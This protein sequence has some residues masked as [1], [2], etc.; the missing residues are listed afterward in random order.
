[1]AIEALLGDDNFSHLPRH[2][3]ESILYV[4]LYI[5]TFTNGP[6]LPR[7]DFETPDTLNMKTWFTTDTVKIIGCRKVGHMCQPERNLISGFTEYWKDFTPF[8]L[9]LLHLCFPPTYNPA[10]P[11]KLTHEKMLSILREAKSTV[12]ELPANV[13][14][15]EE[16]GVKNLKRNES[17]DPPVPTKRTMKRRL[18]RV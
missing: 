10:H 3:L 1:M 7:L 18:E 13:P 12:K 16:K 5:C 4:I 17:S 15:T 8:A 11:N 9:E 2:D 14:V 6:G